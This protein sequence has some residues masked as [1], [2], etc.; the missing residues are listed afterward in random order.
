MEKESKNIWDDILAHQ[1]MDFTEENGV[2]DIISFGSFPAPQ[3]DEFNSE[4]RYNPLFTIYFDHL[5]AAIDPSLTRKKKFEESLKLEGCSENYIKTFLRYFHMPR[6]NGYK[7][8]L[9]TLGEWGDD[10]VKSGRVIMEIVGWYTKDSHQLYAYQLIMLPPIYCKIRK[11]HILYTGPIQEGESDKIT[12]KEVNIPLEKCIIIEFPEELGGYENYRNVVYQ[13]LNLGEQF[14]QDPDPGKRLAHSKEWDK[15]YYK[16]ISQ[17]GTSPGNRAE[18]SEFYKM[19]LYFR[20]KRTIVYCTYSLLG[21]LSTLLRFL[22]KNF[23]ESAKLEFNLK[24]YDIQHFNKME[25]DWLSSKLSFKEANEFLN[26]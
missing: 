15:K 18:L 13:V 19:S 9:G 22:N 3:W 11:E 16:I 2:C 1:K 25:S 12:W 20:Y 21:G 24:Q 8:M 23:H 14:N 10:L 5:G 17:W 6:S 26:F 7:G 4:N